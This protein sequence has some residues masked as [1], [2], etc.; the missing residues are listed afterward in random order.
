MY[1]QNIVNAETN[2]NGFEWLKSTSICQYFEFWLYNLNTERGRE[3]KNNSCNGMW[4][5]RASRRNNFKWDYDPVPVRQTQITNEYDYTIST[6][7]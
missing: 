2:V 4:F 7:K 3:S 1:E 5:I 6:R